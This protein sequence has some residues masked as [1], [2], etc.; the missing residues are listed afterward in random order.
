MS[1]P[2]GDQYY[3]YPVHL[4]DGASMNEKFVSWLFRFNDVL[5]VDKL[6]LALA[7]LLE[8]GDWRKLGGRLQRTVRQPSFLSL[9]TMLTTAA[10]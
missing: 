3:V 1:L 6:H 7:R 8:H 5:D 9:N 4:G 10:V 2:S